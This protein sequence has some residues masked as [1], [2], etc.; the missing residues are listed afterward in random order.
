[1]R[2][3]V[4]GCELHVRDLADPAVHLDPTPPARA[5][6]TQLD[7]GLARSLDRAPE[8][9]SRLERRNGEDVVALRARA[10]RAE[11]GIDAVR[12]DAD[13]LGGNPGELDRLV[14]AELGDRD[15]GSRRPQ[16]ANESHATVEPVPAGKHLR[17]AE[18]RKVVHGDDRRH[19]CGDGAAERR[20]VQ[21]VERAS[22]ASEADRVPGDIACNARRSAGTAERQE[23]EV[24]PGTI[25]ERSEKA[26]DVSSRS[27]ARLDERGGVDGDPHCGSRAATRTA[28]FVVA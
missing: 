25:A 21:N 27:R 13:P 14:A 28:S 9:F 2:A 7:S 3:A 24:E 16:D 10:V 15:H 11:D 5:H 23:L 12:D 8:V 6:D 18:D 19:G 1:M 4:Q 22:A 20:A 26:A 17:S